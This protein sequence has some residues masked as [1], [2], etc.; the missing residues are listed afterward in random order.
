VEG[1]ALWLTCVAVSENGRRAIVGEDPGYGR[2]APP[3]DAY[4]DSVRALDIQSG[5]CLHSLRGHQSPIE[6]VAI[7]PDGSKAMSASYADLRLWD[8]ETGAC[9]QKL[10]G[11]TGS[12]NI[13]TMSSDGC[14]A[15]TV[16]RDGTLTLWDIDK[17]KCLL[18][19]QIENANCSA[20]AVSSDFNKLTMG[21]SSGGVVVFHVHNYIEDRQH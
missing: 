10:E 5:K 13:I 17:R 19:A 4:E 9:L 2:Q 3:P 12:I 14:R 6:A 20:V 11:P 1:C 7:T 21:T 16:G 8:V 15:V 18:V